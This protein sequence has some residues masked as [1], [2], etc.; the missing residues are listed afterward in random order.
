MKGHAMKNTKPETKRTW[1]V[2]LH[3]D[4][5][6]EE[7]VVYVLDNMTCA[8]ANAEARRRLSE[9]ENDYY[10]AL[11]V[12][13]DRFLS[14]SGSLSSTFGGLRYGWNGTVL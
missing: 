8:E 5:L 3:S 7:D 1:I 6:P 2:A 10:D 14:A 12:A 13:S 11:A 4:V 9:Q